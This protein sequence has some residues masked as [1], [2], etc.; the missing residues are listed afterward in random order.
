MGAASTVAAEAAENALVELAAATTVAEA[1]M[2]AWGYVINWD[3]T[4]VVVFARGTGAQ[5]LR[6]RLKSQGGFVL[7][8]DLKVGAPSHSD[9]LGSAI[10]ALNL[11]ESPEV[12]SCRIFADSGGSQAPSLQF[13]A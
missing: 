1:V 13:V 4:K 8:E 6:K 11:L 3:K 2:A 12:A 7:R 5:T 9:H 10:A